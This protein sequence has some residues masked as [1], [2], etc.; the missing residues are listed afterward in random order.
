MDQILEMGRYEKSTKR[1]KK[2]VFK[3]G[4]FPQTRPSKIQTFLPFKLDT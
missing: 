3:M 2:W 4:D 1:N